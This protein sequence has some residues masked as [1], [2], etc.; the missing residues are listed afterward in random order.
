MRNL[1]DYGKEIYNIIYADPPWTFETFSDK[2]KGRSAEQHYKCMD[3][4]DIYTM[5][6]YDLANKDAVLFL[7]ATFPML[8]LAMSTLQ[9]WGFDY[10]TIAFVWVKQNKVRNSFFTGMGYWTRANAEIVLLGTKGHPKRVS[11]SVHQL[12]VAK[13]GEHSAK[14]AI[15]R[16]RIVELCGNLPRIELFA[17]QNV[18]GWAAWGDECTCLSHEEITNQVEYE[19]KSNLFTL[20]DGSSGSY[21]ST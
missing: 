19:A 3:I 1:T 11:K 21:R 20:F 6:V 16:D 17:R 12:I 8:E 15:V 2:G 9:R 18:P 14:P 4:N 13:R 5:P 10:K 7:W